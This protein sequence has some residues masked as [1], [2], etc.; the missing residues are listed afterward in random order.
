MIKSRPKL[1]TLT[2]KDVSQEVSKVNPKLAAIIDNLDPDDS[3]KLYRVRYPFG[4]MVFDKGNILL[5]NKSGNFVTL[6]HPEIPTQLKEDLSYRKIPIGLVLSKGL[7]IHI[8]I[9]NRVVP[10]TVLY[11]G[12]PFGVW[13]TFDPNTSCFVK[14]TWNVSSGARSIFLL[15]KIAEISGYERL[16]RDFNLRLGPPKYLKDQQKIFVK[17]AK[18]PEFKEKWFS[19]ILL[20]SRKWHELLTSEK[21]YFELNDY[22]L[23]YIWNQSIFWRFVALQNLVWNHFVK[24]IKIEHNKCGTYPL[25]TLKHLVTVG[26]GALPVFI[27]DGSNLMAPI[28]GLK[29]VF[30]DS[31]ELN[32]A[33][34]FM[35][36]HHLCVEKKYC[37]GYYSINEP[38]LIESVPKTRE[39]LNIK[40]VTREVKALFDL[41]KRKVLNGDLTLEN[42]PI[43]HLISKDI[44]EFYHTTPD[45]AGDLLTSSQLSKKDPALV[46]MPEGYHPS[47]FAYSSIFLRG[48]VRIVIN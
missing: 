32:Y 38:I 21:P 15:P 43:D 16:R 1:E 24:Q 33:P 2:W 8:E 29:K 28:N 25:E 35:V 47:E 18:T 4:A 9:E 13:E 45:S 19:E 5:P 27:P 39:V 46:A 14:E 42:T 12:M 3:Y 34:T 41:F 37:S 48:C 26:V 36:P 6:F 22:L 10:F 20:F 40:K 44:F 11:P 23:K 30:L 17:I 31:Y 7:E